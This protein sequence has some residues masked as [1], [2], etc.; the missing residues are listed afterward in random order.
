[1]SIQFKRFTVACN[2]CGNL[3]SRTYA[4][5]HNGQCKSCVTGISQPKAS[6]RLYVCPD[7]G[8]RRLTKYQKDH[9]Y[10][11]DQCTKE[12]DPQGYINELRGLNQYEPD[13]YDSY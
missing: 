6:D 9:R 7:C 2:K 1:M 3:T 4:R 5:Q 11:C 12:A 8:E 10:H 13:P